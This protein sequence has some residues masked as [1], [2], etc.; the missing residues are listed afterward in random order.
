MPTTQRGHD[1]VSLLDGVDGCV[2]G[3]FTRDYA[4]RSS[5]TSYVTVEFVADG[6]EFEGRWVVFRNPAFIETWNFGGYPSSHAQAKSFRGLHRVAASRV[7][8][9]T[10]DRANCV[11]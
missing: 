7:R 9:I 8:E 4:W 3:V 11:T 2:S 5:G 1:L 10:Y 6:I